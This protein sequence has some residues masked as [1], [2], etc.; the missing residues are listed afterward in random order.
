LHRNQAKHG[1]VYNT[2]AESREISGQV[3]AEDPSA[4]PE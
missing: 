3:I 4:A 2:L 1:T